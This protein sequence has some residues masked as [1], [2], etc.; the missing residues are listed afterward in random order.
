MILGNE[1]FFYIPPPPHYA[2][3]TKRKQRVLSYSSKSSSGSFQIHMQWRF[4]NTIH[5]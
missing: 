2:F 4:K 5:F 3:L 1:D